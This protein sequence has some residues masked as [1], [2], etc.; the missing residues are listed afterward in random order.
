MNID[1][2]IVIA[3]F[4]VMLGCGVAG[5]RLARNNSDFMVAGRHLRFWM[6]FPC[7]STVI[8]GGGATFG[9]AKLSYEHGISGAWVTFMFGLGIMTMGLLLSSKMARLR[10]FSISE[11]LQLRYSAGS[12]YISAVIS[13]VYAAM[14]GVVQ[15]IAVGTVLNA[16]LGWDMKT[17]MLVGGCVALGYTLLGGMCSIMLTDV[18]QFVLMVVGVFIFLVPASLNA[19]GGFDQLVARVPASFFHITG[20]GWEKLLMFFLL[21][22]LGIMIGQDIWQRIFTA[23]DART[24]RLGTVSAGVFSVFWGAAM[25]I[26]GMVAYVLF[27]QMEHSQ[28]ALSQVVVAVMSP[29]LQG[30]VIAALLSALLSSCSGQVLAA[31]T[32]IINDLLL[33]FSSRARAI[34]EMRLVRL[35]TAVVSLLVLVTALGIGDVMAA[36]DIAYALLSGCVFVPVV[37]GFFWSR[38]T[39]RGA[40]CSML[41]SLVVTTVCIAVFGAFSAVTIC[42]G[43]LSSVAGMVAGSLLP[44]AQDNSRLAEWERT[45]NEAAPMA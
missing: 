16:F 30:M 43:L 44:R 39:P 5:S 20:I 6:Y 29:G 7:L 35:V 14:L 10:V 28:M 22:Y 37:C 9:A 31:S 18:L 33:P 21:M 36:L 41:V 34:P 1:I 38:A 13:A 15:I 25:A 26:C 8:I 32:L 23:R 4:L 2:L 42:L 17:A 40:M 3:Y 19:V 27:P 45:L 11:M 12:R 24:A